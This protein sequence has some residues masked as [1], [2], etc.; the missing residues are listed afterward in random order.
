MRARLGRLQEGP[1]GSLPGL[2]PLP[3]EQ[4]GIHPRPAQAYRPKLGSTLWPTNTAHG[5]VGLVA[6]NTEY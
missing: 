1:W 5:G 2:A 4:P 3:L 6:I